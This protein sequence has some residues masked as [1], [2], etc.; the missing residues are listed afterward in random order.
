MEHTTIIGGGISGLT[1]AFAFEQAGAPYTLIERAA[2]GGLIR[3]EHVHGCLIELGPDSFLSTKTAAMDLIA[4]LGLAAEVIESND[5]RRGTFIVRD[6]RLVRV[7]EGLTMMIP[8]RLEPVLASDL[9]S[10]AA[11][12]R[13][14]DEP[15][16]APLKRDGDVSIAEFV[17]DHFGDEVVE[18]LAEPLLS[19]VFGGDLSSLSARAVL[20][21][22]VDI[23][24]KHGSLI[25]G[26]AAE[27]GTA[28][29]G[30]TLF[31]SLK[32]GMGS[33]IDALLTR[34]TVSRGEVTELQP[35]ERTLLAVPAWAAAKIVAPL[36]ADLADLLAG[37]RYSSATL[38]ALI[39]DA[40]EV[41]LPETGFGFLVPRKERRHLMAA[42]WV[43]NKFSHRAPPSHT[44]IRAFLGGDV[45]EAEAIT[46]V[47]ADL[48]RLM[49]IRA[50]P[51][52]GVAGRWPNSMPQYEIGHQQR[53]V[54]IRERL[55]LHPHLALTGNYLDGV[56][57]P[58]AIRNAR[59]SAAS[60]LL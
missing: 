37:I 43:P 21:R 47:R 29:T 20:G 54:A 50:T 33:L 38:V 18:Y 7:P 23:E 52:H 2:P 30:G 35:G 56:G 45:A 15:R 34:V 55:K 27:S 5:D 19:G 49:G 42:T 17:G 4:E 57:I 25:R 59:A 26:L 60:L 8:T 48:E 58:D 3:T 1:A 53:V 44:V 6:G 11:K 16:F 24:E 28:T 32:H 13:I 51:L 36:D 40:S 31:R 9:L 39:Y 22:F 10:D 12:Q 14:L 41:S 46:G